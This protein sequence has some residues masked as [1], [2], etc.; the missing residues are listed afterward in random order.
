MTKLFLVL[1]VYFSSSHI[2]VPVISVIFTGHFDGK[3][4]PSAGV[5]PFLQTYIC[6]FNNTC[7]ETVTQDERQ[8]SLGN[9]NQS[10]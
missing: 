2:R 8:D 10:V 9:F 4:L 1:V 5:L 7:Y 6:T 3:A